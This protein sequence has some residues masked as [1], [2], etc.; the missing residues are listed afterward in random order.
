MGS[1][2]PR[3]Q[4]EGQDALSARCTCVAE[5][6]MKGVG[7]PT[8]FVFL[9]H[10]AVDLYECNGSRAGWRQEPTDGGG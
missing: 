3:K 4:A 1:D 6:R 7:K 8:P 10:E 2:A 9:R 5:Q